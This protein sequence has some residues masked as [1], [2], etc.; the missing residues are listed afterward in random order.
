MENKNKNKKKPKKT[1]LVFLPSKVGAQPTFQSWGVWARQENT[2]R[3]IHTPLCCPGQEN[4]L[5]EEFTHFCAAQATGTALGLLT[6]S[7]QTEQQVT[8]KAR[9]ES[10]RS[11]AS[12]SAG[13]TC[14]HAVP[15]AELYGEKRL[16]SAWKVRKSSSSNSNRLCVCAAT[17]QSFSHKVLSRESRATPEPHVLQCQS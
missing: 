15:G 12:K 14:S 4:T 7:C 6:Q 2:Q 16:Q 11:K 8:G 13:E 9:T 17:S 1:I 10:W 5:K 3:G